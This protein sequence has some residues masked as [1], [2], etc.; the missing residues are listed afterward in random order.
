MNA[1]NTNSHPLVAATKGTVTVL[2]DS[3][4]VSTAVVAANN[5]VISIL[6]LIYWPCIE[7]LTA[8]VGDLGI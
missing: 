5:F 3:T 1:N 7:G 6:A 8:M 4:W 2:L